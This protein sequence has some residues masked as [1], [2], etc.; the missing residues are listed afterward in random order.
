[1]RLNHFESEYNC[2][3]VEFFKC[4]F[5]NRIGLSWRDFNWHILKNIQLNDSNKIILKIKTRRY[6]RKCS[7]LKHVE[8]SILYINKKV[9]YLKKNHSM[10]LI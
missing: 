1:M 4:N 6:L 7:L 5:M 3:P 8:I 10:E 9:M 2:S